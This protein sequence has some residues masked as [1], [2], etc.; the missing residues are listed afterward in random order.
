M[1]KYIIILLFDYTGI[2][3]Y[4]YEDEFHKIISI[5]LMSLIFSI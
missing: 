1:R 3:L 5:Y 4:K 2:Y